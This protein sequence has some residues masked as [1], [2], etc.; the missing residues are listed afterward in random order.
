MNKTPQD[1]AMFEVYQELQFATNAFPPMR[2]AHEGYALILEEIDELKAHIWY[3]QGRRDIAAMR[4]EAT[5]VAAMAM[6]FMIDIG[7]ETEGQ[8]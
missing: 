5:Q 3:K 1:I 8:K 6:R 4:K 7:N 2:S